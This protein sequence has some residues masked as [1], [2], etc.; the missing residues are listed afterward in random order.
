MATLIRKAVWLVVLAE[1]AVLAPQAHAD[2]DWF[3]CLPGTPNDC[4]YMSALERDGADP[5]AK[6]DVDVYA[7]GYRICDLHAERMNM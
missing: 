2:P 3:G 1:A 7:I 6:S 4:A 5:G